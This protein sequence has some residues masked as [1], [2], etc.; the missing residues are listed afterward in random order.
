MANELSMARP[1]VDVY[2]ALEEGRQRAVARRQEEEANALS[3]AIRAASAR[4]VRN[5]M[6]DPRLLGEELAQSGYAYAIPSAQEKLFATQK[7]AGEA[8]EAAGKGEQAQIKAIGDKMQSFRQRLPVN[9]PRLLPAWVEAVYADPDLGPFMSQFG[10]KEEVIAG[11]PQDAAGVAQWMEGAS[12]AADEVMK[13][14]TLT[15]QQRQDIDIRGRTAR[16]QEQQARTAAA[17]ERRLSQA[18][19]G[20]GEQFK[21]M[22]PK[23]ISDAGF[24]AGTVA[25]KDT[26]TGKVQVLSAVPATQRP[27]A[28]KTSDPAVTRVEAAAKQ[29]TSQ[30]QNVK[31][32]TVS[33][34]L[35]RMF[36]ASDAKL[37]ETYREQLSGAVRAALRIPG[38]GTLSDQEQAQYGLQLPSLGQTKENNEKI[39]KALINQVRLAKQLPVKEETATPSENVDFVYKDGRFVPV[40]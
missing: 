22:T 39:V 20:P 14:R 38:E 5:G 27:P 32:G 28:P 18:A 3:Q 19:M 10:T 31:T 12:M 24:P 8:I 26:K 30:L 33:G 15:E 4:A 34:V 36:D 9:N 7:A 2:G 25:Q 37:F 35:S 29:L 11:I 6:V 1:Y 13:R 17:Q 16:I 23:E 40:R 21:V